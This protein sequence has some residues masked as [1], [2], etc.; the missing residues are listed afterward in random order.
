MIGY[1]LDNE[2]HNEAFHE[3]VRVLK[4][5]REVDT[6]RPIYILQGA[7]GIARTYAAAGVQDVTGTYAGGGVI[8]TGG[9]H[10]DLNGLSVLEHLA[11][12]TSPVSVAQFNNARSSKDF[13]SRLYNAILAG[14][15]A[16]GMYADGLDNPP[17]EEW[18][19][20]RE[21]PGIRRDL[22][23]LLPII[24]K[25]HWTFTAS[26]H[27]AARRHPPAITKCRTTIQVPRRSRVARSSMPLTESISG[28]ANLVRVHP[29]SCFR[30]ATRSR[31]TPC[32]PSVPSIAR[33]AV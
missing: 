18:E 32:C 16:I 14:A 31:I 12:Q 28:P 4:A 2:L 6:E 30:R 20:F 7:Y 33:P 17:F 13:R 26:G 23:Q 11:G 22:E 15:K 21:L 27:Q 24:R 10:G 9:F 19:S 25:P 5:I 29:T 3:Q 1:Y 8:A